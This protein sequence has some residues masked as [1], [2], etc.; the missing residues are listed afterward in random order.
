MA[1]FIG[2]EMIKYSQFW[3]VQSNNNM[4]FYIQIWDKVPVTEIDKHRA[5]WKTL[6]S[7]HNLSSCV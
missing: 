4:S 5:H 1:V 2:K 3:M 6:Q 7:Q